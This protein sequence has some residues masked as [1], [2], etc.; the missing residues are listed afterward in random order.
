MN[1]EWIGNGAILYDGHILSLTPYNEWAVDDAIS[2][3]E[4]K[5]REQQST[6]V[7]RLRRIIREEVRRELEK[8][9]AQ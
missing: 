4:R 6:E 2:D 7:A 3:Y 5:K 1:F 8:G 9:G